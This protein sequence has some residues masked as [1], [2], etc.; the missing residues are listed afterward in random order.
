MFIVLGAAVLAV[1]LAGCVSV[2]SPF[3][4][5]RTAG[6]DAPAR[7]GVLGVTTVTGVE[8]AVRAGGFVD[9]PSAGDVEVSP[10]LR[11]K[12]TADR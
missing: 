1:G 2:P 8:F 10:W 9:E 4:G 12:A 5:E 11:Q 3:D 6:D 7:A